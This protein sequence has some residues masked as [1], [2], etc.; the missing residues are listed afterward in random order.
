MNILK[1][2]LTISV[3]KLHGA[4]NCNFNF[5]LNFTYYHTDARDK[6]INE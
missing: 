6:E 1:F 4:D 5:N 2:Y 3:S